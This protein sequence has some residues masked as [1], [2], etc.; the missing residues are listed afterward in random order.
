MIMVLG[1]VRTKNK[2][3]DVQRLTS[4]AVDGGS[5]GAVDD[6]VN[7]GNG[8][9][10]LNGGVGDDFLDGG[11]GKDACEDPDDPTGIQ[12]VSCEDI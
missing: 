6:Q 10:M 4:S 7:D 3:L 5:G 8:K 2:D 1:P 11:N 9:D 12:F